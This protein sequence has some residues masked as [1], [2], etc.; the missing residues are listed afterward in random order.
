M[1]SRVVTKETVRGLKAAAGFLSVNH[2]TQNRINRLHTYE[3]FDANPV[4]SKVAGG[5]ATGTAGDRNVLN[6][7]SSLFEYCI[8]G[9]QTILA[10]SL[11]A[12]GLDIAMDQTAN[13]GIELNHGITAKQRHSYIIG[14][15]GPFF[16]RVK[17]KI[18]D[19]SGT[20]DCAIG[21]RKVEAN[22][23]NIDDYL[24]MA[25]LNVI[26]G[27][28]K[29]ETILNNAATTTTDTTNN[30]ADGETHEL[31]VKVSAAGVVTY[32]IDGVA[33]TA[34]A[35]FT[36][37]SADVVMPFLYFLNDTDLVDTL[38]L[39]EWEVGLGQ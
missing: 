25:V 11:T 17:F 16:F 7:G 38:E 19:V 9:T 28:I 8:L 1:Y 12:T 36:F 35:A 2:E 31:K 24:D 37:D 30:W 20:D 18:G 14:T 10:P 29:I 13:D 32:E 34:T 39:I 27:D 21:F 4:T 22:R 3:T 6:V 33:P 23:P 26:S 15:D 5:A